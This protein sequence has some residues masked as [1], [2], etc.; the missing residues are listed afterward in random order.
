MTPPCSLSQSTLVL[1]PRIWLSSPIFHWDTGWDGRLTSWSMACHT[2]CLFSVHFVSPYQVV[3]THLPRPQTSPLFLRSTTNLVRPL[4]GSVLSLFLL[5]DPMTAVLTCFLGLLFLPVAYTTC[6]DLN[7]RQWRN[8]SGNHW[9]MGW[10]ILHLPPLERTSSSKRRMALSVPWPWTTLPLKT[11]ILYP[12]SSLILV[13][14]IEPGSF[15]NS[16]WNTYHL[17]PIH[18]AEDHLQR[19]IVALWVSGNAV[20]SN[21]CPC[22]V[23]DYDEQC[24]LFTVQSTNY[25]SP[26]PEP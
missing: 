7:G 6:S 22:C 26:E 5:I 10:C 18:E 24:T 1:M 21:Q 3:W 25:Y 4:A 14:S 23:P 2:D 17:V 20:W 11:G 13:P 19:S 15:P 9:K 8:K 16:T 12:S